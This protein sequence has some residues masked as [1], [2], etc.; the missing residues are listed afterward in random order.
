MRRIVDLPHPEGP[1]KATNAPSR[2]SKSTPASADTV[3]RPTRKSF[4]SPLSEMPVPP[5]G[6]AARPAMA[7]DVTAPGAPAEETDVTVTPSWG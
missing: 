7:G 6:S 2:L 5:L 3:F 1:S 4:V